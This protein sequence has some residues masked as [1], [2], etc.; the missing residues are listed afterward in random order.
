MRDIDATLWDCSDIQKCRALW[1]GKTKTLLKAWTTRSTSV[2]FNCFL[3]CKQRTSITFTQ[4][5]FSSLIILHPHCHFL[6]AIISLTEV[7]L[8]NMWRVLIILNYLPRRRLEPWSS[9]NVRAN[10]TWS[11]LTFFSKNVSFGETKGE[12]GLKKKVKEKIITIKKKEK[13][14]YPSGRYRQ[15]CISTQG[16]TLALDVKGSSEP[17]SLL[18]DSAPS[19]P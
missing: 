6:N 7:V 5:H 15:L 16:S 8:K 17:K 18:N 2:I 3:M 10:K 1:G 14:I 12:R 9:P 19:F 4:K 11:G 13:A